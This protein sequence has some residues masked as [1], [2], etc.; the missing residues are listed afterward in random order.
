[1]MEIEKRKF[2]NYLKQRGLKFTQERCQIL[3]E[4]FSLHKHF[5]VE[6]IYSRLKE[7][8]EPVSRATIYRTFPLLIESG[9]IKEAFQDER[10]LHFEHTFGHK[11]HDHLLCLRCG[12]IIE[13]REEKIEKLQELI[14]KKYD[15]APMK[16]RL[17]IM[18]YCKEC[19]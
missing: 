19:R 9:L 10:K 14:C 11:H 8:K 4:V 12:K 2:R 6:D 16:H 7:K 13:F 1:M 5:D 18:G 17:A 15:F 3:E